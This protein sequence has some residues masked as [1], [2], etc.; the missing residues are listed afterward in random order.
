MLTELANRSDRKK[1]TRSRE[2]HA[3]QETRASMIIS[4]G[5]EIYLDRYQDK[6]P[7]LGEGFNGDVRT[8]YITGAT[9]TVLKNQE[10]FME[11]FLTQ[12]GESVAV[13]SLG[14]LA[15]RI[16]DI[17]R[18]FFPNM[19]ANLVAEIQPMSGP[20]GSVLTIKPRFTNTGG[21]VNAGDEV[22]VN[23][24]DGNYASDE[25]TQSIG[26][27]D[28]STTT[29]S[30]TLANKPI[31]PG[32]AIL[33]SGGSMVAQD[34]GNG[35]WTSD[36]LSGS[37]NYGTGAFSVTFTT[38]PMDTAAVTVAYR[39]DIEYNPDDLREME[40]GLNLVPVQAK[41]HP[42]RY[43]YSVQSQ[44]AAQSAYNLD[45]QDTVSNLAGQFIRKERDY[46]LVKQIRNAATADSDLNFN[47][48][49]PAGGGLTK[50]QHYSDFSIILSRADRKIF[51]VNNR[52]HCSFILVG[53]DAATIVEASPDFVPDPTTVPVGAHRIGVYRGRVDVILDLGMPADE[54]VFGFRGMQLGDAAIILAE[55]IPLYYTPVFQ[56][57]N[58][59]N[60]QGLLS[61]YDIL[62]NNST[63][64]FKGKISQF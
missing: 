27:G 64:Y 13:A 3:D 45:V 43:K 42:L 9:A 2:N 30:G 7:S 62:V 22:F 57:S 53:T 58:L 10:D 63:Y 20:N 8:Q 41:P 38:A 29:F 50:K 52:G 48:T 54:V 60:S 34:D 6:Y 49:V 33:R 36:D 59:Q 21:D 31:R 35:G 1:S 17:V 24:T 16:L 25:S 44:L 19:I 18:V 61:M 11:N 14:P 5:R 12:Y 28:G 55:W 15:P 51:E 47:A 39:W 40:I 46:R 26:T 23:R 4:E 32:T 37:I 56:N